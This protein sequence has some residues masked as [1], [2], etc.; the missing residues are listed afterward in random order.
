[1][2][3]IRKHGLVGAVSIILGFQTANM[4]A[5]AITGGL[6]NILQRSVQSDNPVWLQSL[7]D[8]VS[9]QCNVQ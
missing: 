7:K 4:D 5:S 1:M 6:S 8:H 9:I 2:Q 3:W